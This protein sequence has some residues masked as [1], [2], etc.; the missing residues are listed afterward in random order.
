MHGGVYP[1]GVIRMFKKGQAYLPAKNVHEQMVVA[2]RVGWL[3]NDLLHMDSPT[4]EKYLMRWKRYTILIAADLDKQH[5]GKNIFIIGKYMMYLPM[6]WFI[7]T[8]FRHKGFLD[9]WPGFVFS[10]FSALRFPVSYW[11]YLT[12]KQN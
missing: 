1:D 9:F 11:H 4:F 12:L 6:Q 3:E 8:F 7:W 2:G 10:L 5:V